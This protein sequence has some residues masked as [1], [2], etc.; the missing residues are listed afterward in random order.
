M[1]K[2]GDLNIHPLVAKLV[3]SE[4]LEAMGAKRRSQISSEQG[5]TETVDKT[6]PVKH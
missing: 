6:D 5:H 1:I 3:D 4:A 2:G